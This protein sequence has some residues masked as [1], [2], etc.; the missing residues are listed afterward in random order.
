MKKLLTKVFKFFI[1]STLAFMVI[2]FSIVLFEDN[3]TEII[4]VEKDNSLSSKTFNSLT[5]DEKILFFT[6]VFS[7]EYKS[8]FEAKKIIPNND[9]WEERSDLEVKLLANYK[10]DFYKHQSWWADINMDISIADSIT[11]NVALEGL[12]LNWDNKFK[13]KITKYKGVNY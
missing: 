4:I 12:K 11:M 6:T 2:G 8:I 5:E 9:K 1:Y 3:P 7:L 10:R 13:S